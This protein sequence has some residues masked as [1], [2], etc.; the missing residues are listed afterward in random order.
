LEGLCDKQSRT[1]AAGRLAGRERF[2]RRFQNAG[3]RRT[4]ARRRLDVDS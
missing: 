3:S 1:V 2:M 4:E